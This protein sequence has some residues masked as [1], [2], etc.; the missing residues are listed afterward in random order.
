MI[1]DQ[2]VQSKVHNFYHVRELE[3]P[4]KKNILT[5]ESKDLKQQFKSKDVK[6]DYK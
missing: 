4:Y 2:I 6:Y 3:T 1:Y 5:K